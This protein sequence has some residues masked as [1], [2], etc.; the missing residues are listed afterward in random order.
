MRLVQFAE[1]VIALLV[2]DPNALVK[3]TLEISAE[4]PQGASDQT[5]RSVTENA[6]QLG[7][8]ISSWD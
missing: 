8:R 3:V 6:S 5:R 4:F 2:S 7:F 1:E